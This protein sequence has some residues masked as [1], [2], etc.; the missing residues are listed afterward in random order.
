MSLGVRYFR[1][2]VLGCQVFLD[3]CLAG[4]DAGWPA[5]NPGQSAPG[6]KAFYRF[7]HE[8]KA[9][10]AIPRRFYWDNGIRGEVEWT[11]AGRN[12][13]SGRDYSYFSPEFLIDAKKGVLRGIPAFGPIGALFNAPAFQTIERVSAQHEPSHKNMEPIMTILVAAGL[14]FFFLT[15]EISRSLCHESF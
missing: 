9:A 12:A 10:S 14:V 6:F 7:D 3:I 15:P 5:R 1:Y 13:L 2:F 11:Q 8:G 4:V